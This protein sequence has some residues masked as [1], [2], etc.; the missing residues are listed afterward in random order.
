MGRCPCRHQLRS[1]AEVADRPKR[2]VAVGMKGTKPSRLT[3]TARAGRGGGL[4]S[5]LVEPSAVVA[6]YVRDSFK[7]NDSRSVTESFCSFDRGVSMTFS[8]SVGRLLPVT[9]QFGLNFS[10]F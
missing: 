3:F 10:R 8:R 1:G 7:K 5:S 2:R 9:A 4:R 6:G